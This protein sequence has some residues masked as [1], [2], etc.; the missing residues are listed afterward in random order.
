[1]IITEMLYDFYKYYIYKYNHI[2]YNIYKYNQCGYLS[3]SIIIKELRDR[4]NLSQNSF[5]EKYGIPVSTLRKWEQ[6]ETTPAPYIVRMLAMQ[7]KGNNENLQK[8][9]CKDGTVFYYDSLSSVLS[10]IYGNNIIISEKLDGVK[11]QNLPLYIKDLFDSFYE[12]QN[13]FNQDVILDKKEDIIW[14]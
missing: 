3:M 13:K 9:E 14:S 1:M 4:T 12:I 10:D 5:A 7:I 8:I 11:S 6:G 2:G